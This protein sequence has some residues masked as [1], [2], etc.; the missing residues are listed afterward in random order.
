VISEYNFGLSFSKKYADEL[1][2]DRKSCLKAALKEL[3]VRRLR[4]MSYWNEHEPTPGVYDFTELDWQF[5]LAKKHGAR[6]SLAVGLRQPRWPETHWPQWTKEMSDNE[7]QNRLLKFIKTVALRYKDHPA[8]ESWQ[9]ENEALL[10]TFGLEGNFDRKRL[11]KEFLLLKKID[12]N[13]PVIM[14]LSDSWG[15]PFLKPVPD[16]YAM[17]IYR[18][19][20][21]KGKY[22]YSRRSPVFY[23]VRGR[24]IKLITGKHVFIHELQTEPWGPK[25]TSEL[26]LKEQGITMNADLLKQNVQFAKDTGLLPAYL[27]GAEWWYWLKIKHNDSSLWNAAKAVFSST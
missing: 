22:H 9:L 17:S 11:R 15:L 21:G 19:V 26:T 7:W 23:K 6:V 25:A 27:W 3:G 2:I 8:L 18:W 5:A 24:L 1:C 10:K 20:Y 13:H 14:S 4:L 12:P 16:I